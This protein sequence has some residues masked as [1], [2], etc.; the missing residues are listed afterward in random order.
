MPR[1]R[2]H[3]ATTPVPKES[4]PAESL[5][6]S[7]PKYARPKILVADA[8]DVAAGL[9][10]RGYAAESGSF[11]QPIVVQDSAGYSL[12]NLSFD[13]PGFTEQEII[14]ADLAGPGPVP[15]DRQAIPP[16]PGVPA[17]WCQGPVAWSTPGLPPW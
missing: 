7:E 5:P 12:L 2:S 3:D 16:P 14:V 10:E 8:P 15:E 9:R 1:R 6:A 4:G 17:L 13:L 11:G